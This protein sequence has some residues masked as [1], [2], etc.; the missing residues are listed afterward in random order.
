M[1]FGNRTNPYFF[2]MQ[3]LRTAENQS[4]FV[5]TLFSAIA[6]RYD[7]ANH[8][9]SGGMDF[10]WRRRAARLI[11]EWKPGKILDL[12]TGSG[13]LAI[14]LRATCPD[15]LVVGADFCHPMLQVAQRKGVPHLITADGLA[16]P[17]ADGVFDVVTVAFG[18][19]NMA[20]WPGALAEMRRVITPGGHLV[21]LDF[22][23]PP[24][25]LRWIYRPYLHHV[26]PRVA[27][28]VTQEKAAYDYL[29]DSIE[30]FP[31]GAAMCGLMREA[32]FEDARC[33]PLS[34]GIVSL[35]TAAKR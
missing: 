14:T 19:R 34:G 22:S 17:F 12:A 8:L 29:G 1:P 3:T 21:V 32:G 31:Y 9:L 25:P 4:D 5:R 24:A 15:S 11:R 18:L 28:L 6:Q 7:I 13:D 2:S 23:V 30:K 26:L 20:S 33:E 10:L 27:A 16:L 35:Y